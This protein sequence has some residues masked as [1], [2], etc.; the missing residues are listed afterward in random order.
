MVRMTNL[1]KRVFF[2]TYGGGH[3]NAIVPVI[4]KMEETNFFDIVVL[5][6]TTSVKVL[7]KNNIN[8]IQLQDLVDENIIESGKLYAEKYHT[9][10]IGIDIEETAAYFGVGFEDL[11][12]KFGKEQ[13]MKIMKDNGRK[14]FLPINFMRETFKT[15]KPDLVVT[16][17]SPRF[18]KASL[19]AANELEIP[20]IRIEQLFSPQNAL[21]P[22]GIYYCVLNEYVKSRLIDRGIDEKYIKVTGQP[23]FDHVKFYYDL[24]NNI[25]KSEYGYQEDEKI[26]LWISPGNKDQESII[27]E[28]VRIEE[29]YSNFKLI[30]KLHPNEDGKKIINQLEKLKSKAKVHSEDLQKLILISDLVITEFSAVGLEAILLDKPLI[31]LN[32][33][34]KEDRVAYAE[35]GAALGVYNLNAIEEA[36]I[37]VFEDSTLIEVLMKN[38]KKFHSDGLAA[39]KVNDFIK[40]LIL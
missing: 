27:S 40:Q 33:T 7:K 25:L 11:K 22:K 4:K 6:L 14:S 1:K 35:A 10:G 23:A 8:F 28:L 34:G 36:I 29:K 26:L 38:R 18:E 24:N 3:V 39:E 31:T 15:L 21:L 32:L 30:I 5:G 16:T 12:L 37:K 9:N 13:A 2:V 19:L 17:S 20:S